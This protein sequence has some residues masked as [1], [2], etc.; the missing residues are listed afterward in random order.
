MIRAVPCRSLS[1]CGGRMQIGS[2]PRRWPVW[3]VQPRRSPRP[4]CSVRSSRSTPT[5]RRSVRSGR[6]QCRPGR[7]LRRRLDRGS[8]QDG[9]L[10]GVF[11]R[12]F[13]VTG[14]SRCRRV[15]GQ[16]RH[17][18]RSGHRPRRL[19]RRRKLRRDV[20]IG[21][22]ALRGPGAALRLRGSAA[23]RRNLPS[24]HTRPDFSSGSAPALDASGNFVIVWQS[25]GQDGDPTTASSAS[26]STATATRSA[27]SS[28]STSTRRDTNRGPA[29]P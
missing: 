12:M 24:T 4:P 11:A 23:G 6:R 13:D 3:S 21:D 9:A 14:A 7:R 17:G 28:R 5:Q 1:I 8:G 26:A 19:E 2:W 15:P 27:A 16:Q 20:D 10:G 29:S 18:R 22:R 25:T